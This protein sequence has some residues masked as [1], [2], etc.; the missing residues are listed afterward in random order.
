MKDSLAKII[1]SNVI[2]AFF[3]LSPV[4]GYSA[5]LKVEDSLSETPQ[6]Y[7]PPVPN[8]TSKLRL[9]YGNDSKDILL[10]GVNQDFYFNFTQRSDRIATKATLNLTFTSSPSLLPGFSH[11][12]IYLNGELNSVIPLTAS[13]IGQTKQV[14]LPLNSRSIK[15]T[16]QLHIAFIGHYKE[17]CEDIA[18]NIIWLSLS[19]HSTLEV[20]EQSLLA[21]NDLSY[22]PNPFF[23]HFARDDAISIPFIFPKK[24]NTDFQQAAAILASYFASQSQWRKLSVKV[25]VDKPAVTPKNGHSFPNASVVFASNRQRPAWLQD[26]TLYPD[27]EKPTLK[28]INHPE[29]PYVK[30][31][32]LMAGTSDELIPLAQTL[33]LNPAVLRGSSVEV[34]QAPFL[35]Q[36][37]AYDAPNWLATDRKIEFSE[38][39]DYPQQLQR[40]GLNPSPVFLDFKLPPDLV[41]QKNQDFP[42][43]IYYRH[44]EPPTDLKGSVLNTHLNYEL[45][46]STPLQQNENG[47]QTSTEHKSKKLN[48]WFRTP[49]DLPYQNRLSFNFSYIGTVSSSRT[50]YCETTLPPEVYSSIEPRSS[51][52]FRHSFH[53][54]QM[55]NLSVFAQSGFPFTKTAD[56]SETQILVP[57]TM[58]KP[59]LQTLLNTVMSLSKESGLPAYKLTVS[60]D[61]EKVKKTDK[62]VIIL[63][64]LPQELN[65]YASHFLELKDVET[66]S[67]NP[68]SK[69]MIPIDQQ[70]E[71][72]TFSYARGAIAAVAEME[73]PYFS[74]RTILGILAQSDADYELAAKTLSPQA[75][76]HQIQG[77]ISVVRNSGITAYAV[78][79]QY[80]IG[81]I[82]W[83]LFLWNKVADNSLWSIFF[84]LLTVLSAAFLLWIFLHRQSKRRQTLY[85]QETPK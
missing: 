18:N 84:T 43:E 22:F 3:L 71:V 54:I 72:R 49:I 77:S 1:A 73:S 78:G 50:G 10:T 53:Y 68:P 20:S 2:F 31:L 75:E 15:N 12:R 45:I 56:L 83:W 82:P 30:V 47:L 59:M 40:N 38:L 52:D 41:T 4:V 42:L 57:K 6:P 27:V 25:E 19:N 14:Q 32:L 36:R 24:A 64:T 76:K 9:G 21:T 74:E 60:N 7:S 58:S 67:M 8:W 29:N 63:G 55:P 62:D 69:R 65:Q 34:L 70:E 33:S 46:L 61:W 81:E 51:I 48:A 5:A 17:E 13:D 85:E 66:L 37:R 35:P 23:D 79:P 11:L 44:T 39:M 80:K 26:K 28:L 16:N